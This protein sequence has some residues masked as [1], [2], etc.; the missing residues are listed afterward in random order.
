MKDNITN[1]M[2]FDCRFDSQLAQRRLN[3]DSTHSYKVLKLKTVSV[4][5][6]GYE[7][8]FPDLDVYLMSRYFIY[9]GVR[10]CEV[11]I[12]DCTA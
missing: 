8:Q 10:R 9:L 1:E 5:P 4:W 6:R 12:K 2:Q 11:L 7:G 3:C